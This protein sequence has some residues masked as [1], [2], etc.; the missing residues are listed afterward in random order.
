MQIYEIQE[1][2]EKQIQEYFVLSNETINKILDIL[3]PEERSV[4]E[5]IIKKES[6][7]FTLVTHE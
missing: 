5:F 6:L 2:K 3:K 4:I 1:V 7:D